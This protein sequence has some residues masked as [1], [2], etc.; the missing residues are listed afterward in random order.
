MPALHTPLGPLAG[1]R[2]LADIRPA[3]R[4]AELDFELP[5][6]VSG[7]TTLYDA[8]ALLRGHLPGDDPLAGYA[9]HLATPG[10]GA[11]TLRDTAG[12]LVDMQGDLV[13][14]GVE[15][16]PVRNSLQVLRVVDTRAGYLGAT[17]LL[18]QAALDPYSLVRDI[19][20]KRHRRA[21]D[22]S[23]GAAQPEERFDLPE[24]AAPAAAPPA[25]P[26]SQPQ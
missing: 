19:Y 17:D 16:V 22:E 25:A 14:L 10:L 15:R 3:D 5:M 1:G 26:A 7:A 12:T 23:P 24:E 9:E 4:L 2:T 8:A 21:G 20:L 6:G 11:S 13:S 18:D